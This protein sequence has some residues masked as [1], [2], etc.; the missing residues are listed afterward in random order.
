MII[1]H[2]LLDNIIA[3]SL[4]FTNLFL[5]KKWAWVVATGFWLI[6]LVGQFLKKK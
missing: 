2:K 5:V 6:H 1:A 4:L 3:L